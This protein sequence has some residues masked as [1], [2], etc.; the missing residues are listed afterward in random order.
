MPDFEELEKKIPILPSDIQKF[1][2]ALIPNQN[3]TMAGD[4]TSGLLNLAESLKKDADLLFFKDESIFK[5]RLAWEYRAAGFIL[6]SVAR[7]T[8][9]T[10]ETIQLLQEAGNILHF[11]GHTFRKQEEFKWAGESYQQ[12]GYA[13][14]E[15]AKLQARSG[16]EREKIVKSYDNAIRSFSRAKGT[17]SAVGDYHLSGKCYYEEQKAMTAKLFYQRSPVYILRILWAYITGYGESF[18]RW[19]ISYVVGFGAFTVVYLLD[20][21][22]LVSSFQTSFAHSLLIPLFLGNTWLSMIQYVYSYFVLGFALTIIGRK[23]Q[24]R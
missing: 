3:D 19:F 5:Y 9:N 23:M 21:L 1:Y 17:F 18:W 7:N 14:E 13:F 22:T 24:S 10:T 6:I 11:A 4:K 8:K 2:E 15:C 12:S 16:E 20:G